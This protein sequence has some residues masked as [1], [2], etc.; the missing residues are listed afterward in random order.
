MKRTSAEVAL[1]EALLRFI[2]T[3]HS[4]MTTRWMHEHFSDNAMQRSW[5]LTVLWLSRK[6]LYNRGW[7]AY[8]GAHW[9]I[10]PA[11]HDALAAL[12]KRDEAVRAMVDG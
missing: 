11:G 6:R 1:D 4:G 3:A 7:I 8:N 12:E 9:R 2:G 10:T 5:A